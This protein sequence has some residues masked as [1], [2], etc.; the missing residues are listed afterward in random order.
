[1]G[2]RIPNWLLETQLKRYTYIEEEDQMVLETVREACQ[3]R[4][5]NF[6]VKKQAENK[7]KTSVCL[8]AELEREN[9]VWRITRSSCIKS[10]S[11]AVIPK[12]NICH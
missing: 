6:L 2:G 5:D 12:K 8:L 11:L 3:M 10:M 7:K 9:S 4:L 1:M